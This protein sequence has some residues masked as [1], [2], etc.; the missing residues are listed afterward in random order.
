MMILSQSAQFE[1]LVLYLS[2][3]ILYYFVFVLRYVSLCPVKT[4]Y[5]HLN[6]KQDVSSRFWSKV[7]SSFLEIFG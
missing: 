5:V 2:I 3:Y 1:V 4:T 6:L 7:I